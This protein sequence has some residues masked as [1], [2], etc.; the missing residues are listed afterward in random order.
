MA[1]S[2]SRTFHRVW[3]AIEDAGFEVRDTLAWI[4]GS[5]FPKSHNIGKYHTKFKQT[6]KNRSYTKTGL[7]DTNGRFAQGGQGM[8]KTE[9]IEIDSEWEGW[10]TALKPALEPICL[11]RKP[12][13]EK[14]VLANVLKW[15][16][17]ALNIDASRVPSGDE[18]S[19]NSCLTAKG[20]NR[21]IRQC[22]DFTVL[23]SI[24]TSGSED[25]EGRF[26]ANVIHDGSDEVLEV[27]PDTNHLS[28]TGTMPH[29]KTKKD[30]SMVWS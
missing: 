25:R 14:T 27:F 4:Y 29:H 26:P 6:G 3:V 7:G 21:M 12:L 16:T 24:T 18:T 19:I 15:G 8:V 22:M 5:G 17:G 1:F 20:S 28:G 2:H 10:G 13:S 30:S 9:Q 23:F 11:A